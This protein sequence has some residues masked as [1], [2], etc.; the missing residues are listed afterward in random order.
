VAL[1][2]IVRDASGGSVPG[3]K[4]T[5][6][7]SELSLVRKTQSDER[8]EFRIEDLPPVSYG[9]TATANG[10]AGA[11]YIVQLQSATSGA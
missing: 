10:F 8:G 7:N 6:R 5:V 11:E 4:I 1:L 2:G 3:T 9:V